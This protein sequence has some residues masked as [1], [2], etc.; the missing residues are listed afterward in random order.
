[1]TTQTAPCPLSFERTYVD[2]FT[3]RLVKVIEIKSDDVARVV[4]Q[5]GTNSDAFEVGIFR[6]VPAPGSLSWESC[7][8]QLNRQSDL[9][10][11]ATRR[12]A[13]AVLVNEGAEEVG[14]SDVNH[15]IFT[16]FRRNGGDLTAT[17]LE[18]MTA[19]D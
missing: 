13:A 18:L 15:A 8:E 11:I 12:A 3:G 10:R 7:F 6:L 5:S 1:M 17:L 16:A 9:F 2:S 19:L 14:S 4:P